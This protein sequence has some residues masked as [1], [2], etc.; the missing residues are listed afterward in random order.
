MSSGAPRFG[1]SGPG[2][3]RGS[4]CRSGVACGIAARLCP[5]DSEEPHAP[6][7]HA[8]DHRRLEAASDPHGGA[9][10]LLLPAGRR[11]HRV[12]RAQDRQGARERARRRRSAEARGRRQSGPRGLRR[13]R[14]QFGPARPHAALRRSREPRQGG[15]PEGPRSRDRRRALAAAAAG[16]G[17]GA[18]GQGQET[19]GNGQRGPGQTPRLQREVGA[20]AG[21]RLP[22]PAGRRDQAARSVEALAARRGRGGGPRPAATPAPRS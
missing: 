22:R 7:A 19:P 21:H 1:D 20:G 10:L 4:R 11:E 3:L 6:S 13:P 2:P 12:C 14:R 18:R 15:P 9:D 5:G 16:A 17:P 8:P